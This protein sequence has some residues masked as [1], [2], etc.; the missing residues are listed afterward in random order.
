MMP[1][2][3]QSGVRQIILSCLALAEIKARLNVAPADMPPSRSIPA[4]QLFEEAIL[5]SHVL[6]NFIKGSL[7]QLKS[8][9]QD[10]WH[11]GDVLDGQRQKVDHQVKISHAVQ[12]TGAAPF[13][14]PQN[15]SQ[16]I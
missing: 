5:I 14:Q 6:F 9:V 7:C 16:H 13:Q 3:T 1:H 15:G 11:N 10:Q 2:L 8:R 4:H 12:A